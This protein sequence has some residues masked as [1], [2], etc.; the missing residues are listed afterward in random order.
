MKRKGFALVAVFLVVSAWGCDQDQDTQ[1]SLASSMATTGD[2]YVAASLLSDLAQDLVKDQSWLKS[3]AEKGIEDQPFYIADLEKASSLSDA[4]GAVELSLGGKQYRVQVNILN[5]DKLARMTN[6]VSSDGLV[7]FGVTLDPDEFYTSDADPKK[8]IPILTHD[9]KTIEITINNRDYEQQ[10]VISSVSGT[11]DESVAST[12]VVEDDAWLGDLKFPVFALSLYQILSDQD[13]ARIAALDGRGK[14]SSKPRGLETTTY[15]WLEIL[16]INLYRDHEDGDPEFEI[17]Q[18]FGEINPECINVPGG[19]RIRCDGETLP[20][21]PSAGSA[22]EIYIRNVDKTNET[23]A[24]PLLVLNLDDLL[25]ETGGVTFIESD[26]EPLVTRKN[27][28]YFDCNLNN[29]KRKTNQFYHKIPISTS[30]YYSFGFHNELYQVLGATPSHKD[31][32]FVGEIMGINEANINTQFSRTGVS[33]FWM[34][35]YYNGLGQL[36]SDLSVKFS[37]GEYPYS[38]WY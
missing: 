1:T 12:L 11:V 36:I 5:P 4:S 3:I 30:G 29:V 37:M 24:E 15:P 19:G 17:Y 13:L 21:P 23:F 38:D 6:Q 18:N 34:P 32:F 25:N 9:K 22:R 7:E 2:L 20:N 33:Y 10:E 8:T 16:K 27:R 28:D 31:D 35:A 26:T 14:E